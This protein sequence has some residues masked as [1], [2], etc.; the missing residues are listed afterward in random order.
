MGSC[1]RVDLWNYLLPLSRFC[2]AESPGPGPPVGVLLAGGADDRSDVEVRGPSRETGVLPR[3]E[4]EQVPPPSPQR[5][6]FYQSNVS[7]PLGGSRL[8][9]LMLLNVS[10]GSH[11]STVSLI[12]RFVRNSC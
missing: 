3:P 10:C 11:S 7:L 4:S 6:R 5:P 1:D 2:G 12:G 9:Q 8:A